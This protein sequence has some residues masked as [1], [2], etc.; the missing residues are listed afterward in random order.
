MAAYPLPTPA[1]RALVKL[2]RDLSLARRRRRLSQVSLAE[3]SGVGLNTLRRLEKGEPSVAL[4]HLA[5]VIYVLGE[6]ERIEKLLDTGTDEAGLL[7][8]DEELPD[9]V[10]ARKSTGAM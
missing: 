1:A 6:I 10:R 7:M 4:E 9:R 8:M 3:R 2:G 5:R